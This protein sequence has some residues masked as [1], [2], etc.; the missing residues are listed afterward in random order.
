VSSGAEQRDE[1]D[2]LEQLLLA[3]AAD[4]DG[5]ATRLLTVADVAAV[6]RLD[7][8]WVYDHAQALGALRLGRGPRSPVRFEARTLAA[9]LR[10]LAQGAEL[11][12]SALQ[13]R[14]RSR[15]SRASRRSTSSPE[16]LPIRPRRA[17]GGEPPRGTAA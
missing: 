7:P 10:A 4:A 8:G 16:L 2:P 5:G 9:S 12:V 17:S 3:A 1:P 11:S 15:E 6:L 14:V 13:P